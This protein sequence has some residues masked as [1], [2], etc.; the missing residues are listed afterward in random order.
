MGNLSESMLVEVWWELCTDGSGRLVPLIRFTP[1]ADPPF[2]CSP[3]FHV[4]QAGIQYEVQ[5][6]TSSSGSS[7]CTT[8]F[9]PTT[10]ILGQ[11][12]SQPPFD[13]LHAFTLIFDDV[14]DDYVLESG[15]AVDQVTSLRAMYL[16]RVQWF[17]L[18]ASSSLAPQVQLVATVAGC[19]ENVPLQY[20][21]STYVSAGRTCPGINGALVIVESSLGGVASATLR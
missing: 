19:F 4:I 18:I 6:F 16:E 2:V 15:A 12:S 9:V 21:G 3:A 7:L 10:V 5:L 1:Q 17:Q 20:N 8:L 14:A 13:D 11:F